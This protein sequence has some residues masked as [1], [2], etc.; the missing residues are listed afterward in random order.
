MRVVSVDVNP[1][2]EVRYL[3]AARG[4]G[5]E[6]V[7][8]PLVRA[9]VSGLPLDVDAIVAAADL[10]GRESSA[11]GPDRLL[12]ERLAEELV[13]LGKAGVLPDPAR[14][15]VL[16]G[17]DL[18]TLPLLDQRGGTGDPEP[19]WRAFADRFRWVAGVVGNHDDFGG[20]TAATG[21]DESSAHL[22]DGQIVSLDGLK[23]G[24]VGGIV[25]KPTCLHRRGPE[26]FIQLF[27]QVLSQ[28]P[29]VLV[30]HE[31]PD[32][33]ELKRSGNP[34]L[35]RWL[36][37]W[38]QAREA[39]GASSKL[40]PCADVR[41]AVCK[42]SGDLPETSGKG[43]CRWRKWNDQVLNDFKLLREQGRTHPDMEKIEALLE[44]E[45][46]KKPAPTTPSVP[47]PK[48]K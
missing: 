5:I 38:A 15:G 24:G 31:G 46:T 39:S 11:T 16:L 21:C 45:S 13:Q 29:D 42:S 36:E 3:N 8:L 2:G 28:R 43:F 32:F 1:F 19:V 40:R 18:Y 7:S 26:A 12:G 25:G 4:G 6:E 20:R 34:V 22:L 30:C 33:P 9:W 17:G 27:E 10:Q 37:E 48:P 44:I 41:R 14:T 35:R 47:P 23:I